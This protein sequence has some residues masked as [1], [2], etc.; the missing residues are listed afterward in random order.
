M[1]LNVFTLFMGFL[2]A[3]M[4][5][6]LAQK[7]SFGPKAG[8]NVIPVEKNDV[9]G[10]IYKFGWHSGGFFQYKL[11]NN[12]SLQSELYYNIK[13]KSYAFTDT[14]SLKDMLNDFGDIASDTS[15]QQAA[16]AFNTDVYS[17][18]TGAV[19][20]TH[21]ELPVLVTYNLWKSIEI[22]AGAYVSY[23]IGAKSYEKL[24]QDIPLLRATHAF[25]TIPEVKFFINS[26]YPA[27]ETPVFT[28]SSGK[29]KYTNFDFGWITALAYRTEADI[30]FNVRY[31]KGIWDYRDS[32]SGNKQVHS[33]LQFSVAFAVEKLRFLKTNKTPS[34]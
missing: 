4:N 26:Y 32:P 23:L 13:R 8:V 1:S 5:Y 6:S 12:I 19:R 7:L 31:T 10:N 9:M 14:S 15:F 34:I 2:I 22:S 18:T 27:H 25:D 30:I 28:T 33:S 16:N 24:E 3:S 29:S 21:I 17:K 20:Q 11:A